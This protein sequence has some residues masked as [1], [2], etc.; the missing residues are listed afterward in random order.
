MTPERPEGGGNTWGKIVAR[1]WADGAFRQRLVADPAAVL[2][3]HGLS[4]PEGVRFKV[5]E[6]TDQLIH[7]TLPVKPCSD[8]LSDSELTQVVGG[9]SSFYL[10]P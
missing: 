3:E 10:P 9:L 7:L 5:L 4:V 6:D 1:A 8:E 2:K